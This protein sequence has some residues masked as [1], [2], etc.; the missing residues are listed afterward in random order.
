MQ[1]GKFSKAIQSKQLNKAPYKTEDIITE[2]RG[3]ET[4]ECER[5]SPEVHE[6]KK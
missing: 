3:T 4:N 6:R 5:V 1:R 2:S